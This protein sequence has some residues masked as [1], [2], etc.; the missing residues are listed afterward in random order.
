MEYEIDQKDLNRNQYATNSKYKRHTGS[1]LHAFQRWTTAQRHWRKSG[2]IAKKKN[3][4]DRRRTVLSQID[5]TTKIKISDFYRTVHH[6]PHRGVNP[7]KFIPKLY[8]KI[9]R[10][11]ILKI[12][13]SVVTGYDIYKKKYHTPDNDYTTTHTPK[14]PNFI[15]CISNIEYGND[16]P[17]PCASITLDDNYC[18][19]HIQ[20]HPRL[21]DYYK[22]CKKYPNP[23][24]YELCIGD[25][26]ISIDDIDVSDY[27]FVTQYN[28][29]KTESIRV[30]GWYVSAYFKFMRSGYTFELKLKNNIIKRD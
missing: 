4:I 22:T 15:G 11:E 27:D 19:T 23:G 2:D 18:V 3:N 16:E 24:C 26:L 1:R 21:E 10:N 20:E 9:K 6:G 29:L 12:Y 17:T 8:E 13:T 28:M 5:E 14:S 25:K 7:V 30:N